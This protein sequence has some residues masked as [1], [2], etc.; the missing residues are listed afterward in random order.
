VSA[1]RWIPADVSKEVR[2]LV[3]IWF[4]C[5]IAVWA[6]GLP[7]GSGFLFRAG[8]LGFILGSSA[9]GAL[10][11]GH[12]YTHRTLPLLLAQPTSRRRI[13]G[14][15]TGVLLA[16]LSVLVAAALAR[17]PVTDIGRELQDTKLV[18]LVSLVG[19][20]CVAPWLT[21]LSRNPLAGALFSLSIGACVLVGSELVTM[22][23]YGASQFETSTAQ[24]FREEVLWGGMLLLVTVGGW[25]S[26]RSFMKLESIEGPQTELRLPG[27]LRP[28]QSNI[29]GHEIGR[30][31]H[32]LWRLFRK[33]LRLQQLTFVVAGLYVF[34][35]G[36]MLIVGR[37]IATTIDQP[38]VILTVVN[39]VVVALLA[40][41]LASAEERHLGTLELQLLQP[42][43][44]WRQWLVKC[45]VAFGVAAA[46]GLG[47]PA[48]LAAL[49][50]WVQ[51]L[52]MNIGFAATVLVT[53]VVSLYVS[54]L[55]NSGV[56][57][58][59]IALPATAATFPVVL[60]SIELAHWMARAAKLT[61]GRAFYD[62]V[63][64]FEAIVM[65]SLLVHFASINH[66][67]SDSHGKR[68]WSQLIVVVI[69]LVV[70]VAALTAVQTLV[71]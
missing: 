26:W 42:I 6:G 8:F 69:S 71:R 9:L 31:V 53:A 7:D 61:P 17:L 20:A 11:V 25:A 48:A 67:M 33:E 19:A 68:A 29:G 43:P 16:M 27:W 35:W 52:R 55:S 58:L 23:V 50:Q 49:A 10:A 38:F 12:E 3:P 63:V 5:L 54:S 45:A 36:V 70:G 30:P 60:L 57:A 2:A 64:P 37:V 62:R 4:G 28:A 59:L 18:G 32:P 66:R 41:S 44:F 65:I 46:L 14:I 34:G 15:K 13:F 51:P 39:G 1:V 24:R 40:G 47:L 21:M 22:V 56:K